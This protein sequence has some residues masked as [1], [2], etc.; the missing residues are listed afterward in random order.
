MEVGV[1]GRRMASVPEPVVEELR[2]ST[3]SATILRE[4]YHCIGASIIFKGFLLL[5][6]LH[7]SL[8]PSVT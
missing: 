3:E 4:K 2:P 1:C 6:G 8:I 7:L 5:R